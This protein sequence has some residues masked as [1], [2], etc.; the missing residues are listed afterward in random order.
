MAAFLVFIAAFAAGLNLRLIVNNILISANRGASPAAAD[1][2]MEAAKKI[3]GGAGKITFKDL[4]ARAK[5]VFTGGQKLPLQDLFYF[6][7]SFMFKN[8]GTLAFLALPFFANPLL[9]LIPGVPALGLGFSTSFLFYSFYSG[10]VLNKIYKANLRDSSGRVAQPKEIADKTPRPRD[11]DLSVW[12]VLKTKESVI[13]YTIAMTL[14]VMHEIVVSSGYSS[15]LNELLSY[16]DY[17]NL[18]V[19]T[20][21]YVPLFLGRAF[22][23]IALMRMSQGSTYILSSLCS[24]LGTVLMASYHS[25]AAILTAG[26]ALASLGLS[27]FFGQMYSNITEKHLAFR[28]QVVL[29]LTT[30]MPLGAILAVPAIKLM[31]NPDISNA[32]FIY[33]LAA[34]VISLLILPSMVRNSSIYKY[35]AQFFKPLPAVPQDKENT[36]EAGTKSYPAT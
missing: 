5:D 36:E 8:L 27:N 4:T 34:L 33:A 21:L 13:A 18:L 12:Q 35:F 11:K 30:T 15:K 6:N 1:S 17:A 9:N 25:S 7:M 14:G 32:A 22:W 28:R 29:I 24:L 23:N 26:A 10:W 19:G 20:F 3:T 16:S 2:R 31:K